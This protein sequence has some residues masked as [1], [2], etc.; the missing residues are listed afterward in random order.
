VADSEGVNPLAS[1]AIAASAVGVRT[2]YMPG[3]FR[4]GGFEWALTGKDQNGQQ[5]MHGAAPSRTTGERIAVGRDRGGSGRGAAA[6][7]RTDDGGAEAGAVKSLVGSRGE[8]EAMTPDTPTPQADGPK[9]QAMDFTGVPIHDDTTL[10]Y[11]TAWAIQHEVGP[12]LAHHPRCSS[13]PGWNP[14]SGPALLCDCGAVEAEWKRRTAE[15]R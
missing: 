7:R 13:V 3:K 11:P 12:T 2:T 1:D 9:I 6:R 5:Y 8:G 4:Q 15:A 10:D 14:I